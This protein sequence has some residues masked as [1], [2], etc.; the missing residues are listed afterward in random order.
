V[1]A[2]VLYFSLKLLVL[3]L[4][5]VYPGVALVLGWLQVRNYAH[6]WL[7]LVLAFVG[8][9]GL[10]ALSIVTIVDLIYVLRIGRLMADEH[11]R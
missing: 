6:G 4:L 8:I 5:F 11:Q 2:V 10:L 9:L 1:L 3:A 7:V